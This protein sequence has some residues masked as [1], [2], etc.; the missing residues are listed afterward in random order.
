MQPVRICAGA[1]GDGL[2]NADL[3]VTADHGMVLDGLVINASAL[4]NGATIDWVPLAE[5]STRVT[6]YHVETTGHEVILANGAPSESFYTGRHAMAAL[7]AEQLAE[8]AEIFPCLVPGRA[9]GARPF[10][11]N[12]KRTRRLIQ[13]MRGN[14]K[15]IVEPTRGVLRG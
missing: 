12:G 9:P 11:P 1:L 3:T 15:V 13:R 2:P 5:L 14:R 7:N 10:L 8:I 4:V 6:Y